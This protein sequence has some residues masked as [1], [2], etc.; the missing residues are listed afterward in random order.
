[1]Y[2]DTDV[3]QEP[4]P[5]EQPAAP[6]SLRDRLAAKRQELMGERTFLLPIPG[7]DG[8]IAARYRPLSYEALRRIIRKNG[9]AADNATA[10]SE[11]ATALDVLIQANVELVERDD[12]GA[13]RTLDVR[14]S[15][16]AAIADLFQIQA[17]EGATARYILQEVF[18]G[19]SMA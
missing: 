18:A 2:H 9:S 16:P 3:I 13:Y 19:N 8:I 6:G 5:V 4:T 10:E 15:L 11:L 14:W 7:Y 17:P 12:E 1:M